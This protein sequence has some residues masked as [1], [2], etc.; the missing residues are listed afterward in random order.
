MYWSSWDQRTNRRLLEAAGLD[1]IV[2]TVETSVEDGEQVT[3]QWVVA[4]KP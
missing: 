1:V 4:R 2:D 3:F